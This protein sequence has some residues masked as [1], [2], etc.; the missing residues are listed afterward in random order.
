MLYL[1]PRDKKILLSIIKPYLQYDI[2]VYGSR[3]KGTQ[4]ELS[5]LDLCIMKP[6]PFEDYDAMVE[7]FEESDLPIFVS[8]AEW[9][10]LSESFK[11]TIEKDLLPVSEW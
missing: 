11:Q 2:R 6:I 3:A 7:A 8:I 5:D 10:K 4:R 9:Q 1:E